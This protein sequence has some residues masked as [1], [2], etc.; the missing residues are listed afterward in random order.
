MSSSG[1]TDYGRIEELEAEV[2]RLRAASPHLAVCHCWESSKLYE[3]NDELRAERD[4]LRVEVERLREA[5]ASGAALLDEATEWGI[6]FHPV[7]S[8]CRGCGMDGLSHKQDCRL[9]AA[10]AWADTWRKVNNDE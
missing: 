9:V 7:A 3:D 2:E 4:E 8:V 1:K 5:L 10:E 6:D